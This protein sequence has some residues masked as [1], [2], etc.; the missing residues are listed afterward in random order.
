[1]SFG[2]Y[3]W[4]I[5]KFSWGFELKAEGGWMKAEGGAQAAEKVGEMTGNLKFFDYL[6]PQKPNEETVL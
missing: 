4:S 6:C 5:E 2:K 3:S 1:M